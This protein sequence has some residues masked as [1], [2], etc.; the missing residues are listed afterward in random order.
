MKNIVLFGNCQAGQLGYILSM[1]L[2]ASEFNVS[3]LSNNPR[4]GGMKSEEVILSEIGNCDILIY[5]PLTTSH[6]KLSE[7]HINNVTKSSCHSISFPYI[8]NDGVYSLCHAPMSPAHSYG[9]IYG[10]EAILLQLKSGRTKRE[11]IRDWSKGYIDFKLLDRFNK[12]LNIMAEQESSTD[13]KLSTFIKN[14]Y[15]EQKLFSTQR[16]S[17]EIVPMFKL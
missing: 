6:G 15:R 10:E 17:P 14:N 13:I 1:L 5:Q 12:C 4:T 3:V 16:R 9:K 11:I 8:F 7:Y 2:P